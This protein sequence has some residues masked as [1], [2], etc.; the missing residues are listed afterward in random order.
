MPTN[1]KQYNDNYYKNNKF[2]ILER[3]RLQ[4]KNGKLKNRETK[5]IYHHEANLLQTMRWYNEQLRKFNCS[6]PYTHCCYRTP[7]EIEDILVEQ[8]ERLQDL[9]YNNAVRHNA[10]KNALL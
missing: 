6:V 10:Y 8:M 5:K 2:K 9:L 3:R 7:Q 4:Y 1:T